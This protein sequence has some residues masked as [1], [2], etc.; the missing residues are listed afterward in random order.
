MIAPAS[1]RV[2]H[3][4]RELKKVATGLALGS[5]WSKIRVPTM[6]RIAMKPRRA[7]T[8]APKTTTIRFFTSLIQYARKSETGSAR[9]KPKKSPRKIPSIGTLSA[10]RYADRSMYIKAS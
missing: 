4:N 3:I 1:P 5:G 7:P 8:N 6:P 10:G 2:E 9:R